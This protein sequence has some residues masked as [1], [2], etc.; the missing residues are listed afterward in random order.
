MST[1]T[2]SP[3]NQSA[4]ALLEIDTIGASIQRLKLR[5]TEILWSGT[6]P[7]GGKG[8]THPCIPNFNI[9][10]GLPN[11]GPARKEE[12]TQINDSSF[13]WKMQSIGELFPIGL[14]AKRIFQLEPDKLTTI[15]Q[16]VNKSS[17]DLPINIAEH[18][19]FAC[20]PDKRAQVKVNGIVFD[21]D[22]LEANAKYSLIGGNELKIEIPNLPTI[23]MTVDGYTA[24]AQWSQPNAPFVCVEPIQVL[25]PEPTQFMAKAP[26]IKA[27]ETKEF[28]YELKVI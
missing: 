26:Q 2:I 3:K 9:A 25:P 5:D 6:R 8:I 21:K 23:V 7:D 15:T 22:G 11:H 18:N 19:Y 24:F 27:G 12:W 28:R 20:A 10:E 14:E 13:S 4:S 16:I 17:R 1:I